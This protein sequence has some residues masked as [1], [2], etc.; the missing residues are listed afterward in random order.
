M[1][2]DLDAD[3]VLDGLPGAELVVPGLRDLAAGRETVP[4]LLVA[5]AAARLRRQNLPVADHQFEDA[6]LRLYRLL[7]REEPA[8][9]YERYNA[10]LRRLISFA[11]ALEREEGQKIRAARSA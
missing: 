6:E 8:G 5:I 9:A 4:A 11:H 1:R 10:L 3:R 7:C 2:D